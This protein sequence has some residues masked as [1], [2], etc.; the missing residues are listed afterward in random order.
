M[1]DREQHTGI[2]PSR[3]KSA[4]AGDLLLK[5]S[6]AVGRYSS[7]MEALV[8]ELLNSVFVDYAVM[9]PKLSALNL[10]E[11]LCTMRTYFEIAT[12]TKQSLEDV[13]R[14]TNRY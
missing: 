5:L 13:S 10:P 3:F 4:V 8:W 14:V 1:K 6:R 9:E 2:E 11:A 12:E 7:I